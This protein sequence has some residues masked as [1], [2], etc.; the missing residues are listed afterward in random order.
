MNIEH[1][2]INGFGR[3]HNR[4]L[5]L[6]DGVTILYGRNEAGKSTTLQFIRSMLF[7]IPSRGNLAE[8][9]E[10]LQGGV[11]GGI[12]TARGSEGSGWRIR[13]R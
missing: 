9:Y 1:L 13:R 8:R 6:S 7:G 4:E 2:H 5:E 3:I 10:P 11:H 12:L